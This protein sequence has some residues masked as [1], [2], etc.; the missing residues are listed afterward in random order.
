MPSTALTL[1]LWVDLAAVGLAAVQGAM[2]AARL[3]ERKIDLLGVALI[4]I[5]VGLGGGLVRDVLLNQLPAALASNWYLLTTS[6]AALA[7]MALLRVVAKLGPLII[8]LDAVAL[9]LFAAT[10]TAKALE[11]GLPTVPTILVGLITAVGGGILRDVTLSVPVAVMHVGSLYAI[12]ATAGSGLLIALVALGVDL[13]VAA[14]ACVLV[15]TVIRLAAVRFGW[16]LPEQRALRTWKVWRPGAAA[17]TETIDVVKP[18]GEPDGG[19][20]W[21]SSQ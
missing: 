14:A 20:E 8:A 10:G 3:K 7:G 9:G 17:L 1:P 19:S 18:E 12:A 11:Y 21:K 13:F 16:S 4:G 6:V 15:T 5:I 2:F